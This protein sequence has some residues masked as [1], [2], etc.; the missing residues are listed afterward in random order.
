[1]TIKTKFIFDFPNRCI[2]IYLIWKNSAFSK[3]P[4]PK[5]IMYQ[6]YIYFMWLCATRKYN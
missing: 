2:C 6:R 1:M 3:C 4:V 5:N